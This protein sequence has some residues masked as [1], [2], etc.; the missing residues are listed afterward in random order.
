MNNR[1]FLLMITGATALLG[2][3]LLASSCVTKD[4]DPADETGGTSTGGTTPGSGGAGGAGATGTTGGVPSQGGAPAGD[5]DAVACPPIGAALLTDFTFAAGGAA[6]T[7]QATFG[8]PGTTFAGG[9]IVYPDSMVSDVTGGNWNITG[10]VSDYTGFGFYY[11]DG[12]ARVDASQYSGIEFRVSGTL[13][14]GRELRLWASTAAND[15]PASWLIANG[16]PTADPNFGRCIP[17]SNQWDGTCKNGE[18]LVPVTTTPTLIQ[19][20]WADFTGGAPEASVTPSE[21]SRFGW[22]VEWAG[23]TDTPYDIDITIDDIA[24]ME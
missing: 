24:F 17:V 3:A 12:C 6:P 23:E 16:T 2:S 1:R 8:T 11:Q 18:Y 9:T 14:A 10:T 13:P 15:I 21:L 19:V 7:T 22:F 4:E 5:P 20:T